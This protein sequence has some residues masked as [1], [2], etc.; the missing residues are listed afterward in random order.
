MFT[1]AYPNSSPPSSLEA[2]AKSRENSHLAISPNSIHSKLE[3]SKLMLR[4]NKCV[5]TKH[6][7]HTPKEDCRDYS[8]KTVGSQNALIFITFPSLGRR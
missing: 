1:K 4:G 5:E 2:I 7:N 3:F 8:R 6:G